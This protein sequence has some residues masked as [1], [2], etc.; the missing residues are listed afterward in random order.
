MTKK[1][2]K[3]NTSA[4]AKADTTATLM[5]SQEGQQV[6]VV[7]TKPELF[8][9]RNLM[10]GNVYFIRT[11]K[12]DGVIPGYD[13]LDDIDKKERKL[14]RKSGCFVEGQIVEVN[15][16]EVEENVNSLSDTRLAKLF[17]EYGNDN[18]YMKEYVWS[19]EST[20][21]IKRLKDYTIA[22]NHSAA[23]ASYCDSRTIEIEE[24]TR[25]DLREP[26]TKAPKGL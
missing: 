11:D 2:K 17:Q 13:I 21:A 18:S 23:I 22:N 8:I 9:F 7:E 6:V 15:D 12:S 19:M 26:I 14:L 4:K 3:K 20:F 25:E 10:P 24:Q 1:Q 16:E 5:Q